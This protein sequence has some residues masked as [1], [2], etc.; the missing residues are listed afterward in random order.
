VA[1]ALTL[2]PL[3]GFATIHLS[4][5]RARPLDVCFTPILESRTLQLRRLAR[6][7]TPPSITVLLST[8]QPRIAVRSYS[9]SVLD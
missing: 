1:F 2:Q 3:L 7:A 5:V 9:A 8:P 6:F 4:L